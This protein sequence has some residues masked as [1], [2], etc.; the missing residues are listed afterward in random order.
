MLSTS[1]LI[2]SVGRAVVREGVL[3]D[4]VS[5]A[6][7][8]VFTSDKGT[9]SGLGAW[10]SVLTI[11]APA[12][13][14]GVTVCANQCRVRWLDVTLY[15]DPGRLVPLFAQL[16]NG[17]PSYYVP[18]DY[19]LEFF[20]CNDQPYT[21]RLELD[22]ALFSLGCYVRFAPEPFRTPFVSFTSDAGFRV[23]ASVGLL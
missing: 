7:A 14:Y 6:E 4:A 21:K 1:V 13:S 23:A 12:S 5:E 2:D 20:P 17:P 22:G 19:T 3:P 15:P 8:L 11:E 18:P 10:T 16:Y 9:S